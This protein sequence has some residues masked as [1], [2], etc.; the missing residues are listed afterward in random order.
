MK[1]PCGVIAVESCSADRAEILRFAQDDNASLLT[2]GERTSFQTKLEHAW[3]QTWS[4]AVCRNETRK[5]AEFRALRWIE[6]MP[7]VMQPELAAG[8]FAGVG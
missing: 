1:R 2:L 4:A 6:L 7:L 8:A 5:G 3:L